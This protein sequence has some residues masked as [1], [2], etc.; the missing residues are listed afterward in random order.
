[1]FFVCALYCVL[2]DFSKKEK[3]ADALHVLLCEGG[4]D[5]KGV[6]QVVQWNILVR[7]YRAVFNYDES[8][9][10]KLP[11][12]VD[13]EEERMRMF[14]DHFLNY[15]SYTQGLGMLPS[16]L[17][18]T[19]KEATSQYHAYKKL[20]DEFDEEQRKSKILLRLQ[21]ALGISIYTSPF[22]HYI[23]HAERD[24]VEQAIQVLKD[25][26]VKV[27]LVFC[28]K[29]IDAAV[30]GVALEE[31]L[32]KPEPFVFTVSIDCG[33]F[34]DHIPQIVQLALE[35]LQFQSSDVA[36]LRSSRVILLLKNYEQL[37]KYENIY[38]KNQ[39]STWKN[40]QLIVTCCRDHFLHRSHENCFLPD[41]TGRLELRAIKLTEVAYK[42]SELDTVAYQRRST[43]KPEHFWR[44]EQP[45]LTITAK[46]KAQQLEFNKF[47]EAVKQNVFVKY[48][49]LMQV[50]HL[51][52]QI[53][54]SYAW[55]KDPQTLARQQSHLRQLAHDLTLLGFITWLDVER[56]VGNVDEQMEG[57]IE[58]SSIAIV[59]CTPRYTLLI[60][61][62]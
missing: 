51:N 57:N 53:F 15:S 26:G 6:F 41:P 12:W 42:A 10:S 24:K 52:A 60:T 40:V 33:R 55:E 3:R 38:V 29:V 21:K 35:E 13:A 54:I 44:Q 58:S 22:V 17:G 48:G 45:L 14:I 20:F 43:I 1:M 28:P 23:S 61:P 62:H 37:G 46:R 8:K 7:D 18:L 59:I 47:L 36:M 4:F 9:W 50:Y 56:M 49:L 2:G 25:P 34:R 19:A 27:S 39:L 11:P 32:L 5:A 30:M 31:A 16:F